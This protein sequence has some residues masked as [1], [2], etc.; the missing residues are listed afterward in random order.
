MHCNNGIV[1]ADG[2]LA[3]LLP[4]NYERCPPC[5]KHRFQC[6]WTSVSVWYKLGLCPKLINKE[7]FPL[8]QMKTKK[9]K[10]KRCEK[11]KND[12]EL[13]GAVCMNHVTGKM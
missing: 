13:L 8:P 7:R 6:L 2:P 5:Y 10:K 3:A 12:F 4:L 1:M 9:K 11:R